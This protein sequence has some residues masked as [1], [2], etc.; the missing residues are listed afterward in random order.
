MVVLIAVWRER[1]GIVKAVCWLQS[2]KGGR[3]QTDATACPGSRAWQLVAAEMGARGGAMEV[4][5]SAIV[6]DI[7]A[8]C[9]KGSGKTLGVCVC[10]M[11]GVH[12]RHVV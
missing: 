3:A 10:L 2:L 6:L 1:W 5:S 11:R 7:C 12:V 9:M 4:K 8:N